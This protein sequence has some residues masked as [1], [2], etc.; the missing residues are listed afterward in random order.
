MICDYERHLDNLS[1]SLHKIEKSLF[2]LHKNLAFL[3]EIEYS[4][5]KRR[6]SFGDKMIN[7][8]QSDFYIS[9]R[10]MYYGFN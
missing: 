10:R 9:G 4:V 8:I 1:F 2:D 6:N 7:E 5:S 3:W